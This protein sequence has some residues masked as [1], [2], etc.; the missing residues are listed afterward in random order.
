MKRILQILQLIWLF[1]K[2]PFKITNG[3][4]K[5]AYREIKMLMVSANLL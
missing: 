3:Y 5:K 1:I 4:Q 2:L